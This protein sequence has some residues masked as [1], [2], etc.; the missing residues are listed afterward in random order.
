MSHVVKKLGQI[1]RRERGRYMNPD[2]A[3]PVAI[4]DYGRI[5]DGV[6]QRGGSLTAWFQAKGIQA[7]AIT[8]LVANVTE[9]SVLAS[10]SVT[11]TTVSLSGAVNVPVNGVPVDA[12][13][14]LELSFEEENQ[15]YFHVPGCR[16][17]GIDHLA[18]IGALLVAHAK[19]DQHDPQFWE[20]DF[21]VVTG[22]YETSSMVRLF[23]ERSKQKF[24]FTAK[25]ATSVTDLFSAGAEFT[26][27]HRHDSSLSLAEFFASPN[28]QC[29][30]FYEVHKVHWNVFGEKWWGGTFDESP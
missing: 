6:F 1:V 12:A 23:S 4:G 27:L 15:F 10:A 30:P 21:C 19:R 29:V 22:A 14:G 18:D 11:S 20:D 2:P 3:R 28:Q 8:R 26:A 24:S 13:F 5:R 7:P 17:V 9:S 25:G 16:F